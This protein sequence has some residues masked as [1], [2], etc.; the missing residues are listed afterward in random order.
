M[1]PDLENKLS[2]KESKGNSPAGFTGA[3]IV[4][5][6]RNRSDLAP[7]AIQSVLSQADCNLRVIVSDN[8]TV[9]EDVSVLS[10][11]CK[12]VKDNRLHYV[13]PPEPLAMSEHWDW[14]LRQALSIDSNHFAFLTDRMVFRPNALRTVLELVNQYPDKIL[15]YLHDRVRDF[16]RPFGVDLNEWTGKL[17]EVAST[18]L[19]SL[20][21]QSIMYAGSCPRML[22]CFV[23]RSV[24]DAIKNRFGTVFSS[25]APDWNFT[26]RALEVVD[27][28]LYFNKPVLVHYALPRSNGESAHRGI[29]NQSYSEFLK[30]LKGPVNGD[31]PF[32]EIITVWNAII[33]EY[34]SVKNESRSLKFP[35]LDMKKYIQALASGIACIEN[36]EVR[37]EMEQRLK[38]RGGNPAHRFSR[39]F[40]LVREMMSPR[41]V[42]SKL[43]SLAS[44]SRF[45][46]FDTPEQALEFAVTHLRPIRKAD[47]WEEALH[48]GVEVSPV[49]AQASTT[50]VRS[51]T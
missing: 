26:Y 3:T 30:E 21:A 40:S 33:S 25:N 44:S 38:A 8:S 20:S 2:A 1:V 31:A 48:Q 42:L 7:T 41:L 11:Y 35:E 5:P 18:R 28:V 23:P 13:R 12:E 46:T 24:L 17:Y 50:M 16:C 51:Q 43:K 39:E 27:S 34:C 47:P 36:V 19:L 32:P 6:T 37:R 9:V 22:N 15:T 45:M 49:R 14:A 29:M 4:I 10:N